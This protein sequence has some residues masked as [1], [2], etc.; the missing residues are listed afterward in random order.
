MRIGIN[1]RL[2]GVGPFEGL[3]RYTV[4]TTRAMA[5]A[6]PKDIFILFFDRT[7]QDTSW[8]KDCTNISS[9]IV[10]LPTRHPVLM[11]IWFES[12][13][14]KALIKAQID[15]FYSADNFLSLSSQIPTVLVC[16]DLAYLTYPQGLR[17]DHL[18]FYRKFMPLYLKRAEKIITVSNFVKQDIIRNHHI[19]EDKITVAGNALPV[20]MESELDI[21]NDQLKPGKYFVYIGSI[22]PRKNISGLIQAFFDFRDKIKGYKLLLIGRLAW[23]TEE[24]RLILDDPDIVKLQNVEDKHLMAYL[25]KA[26]ALIYPSFSEGFGIPILEG[27]AAE[28]P[29]ITSDVTSMPEVAG[30]AAL[31]INPQSIQSMTAAMEKI[32]HEPDV[33]DRL[34]ALGRERLDDFSWEQSSARIY[35]QIE[36][37]KKD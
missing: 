19:K 31:L 5:L 3:A 25:K 11:L 2:L 20:R 18:W 33:R 23:K 15:V 30:E 21:E 37:V 1:A 4:E 14:R 32:V 8:F 22:H 17:W 27:F 34:I 35:Q 6:N 16:H 10:Y 28:I 12:L 24:I 7:P 13:L 29:V 26:T 36:E 9:E